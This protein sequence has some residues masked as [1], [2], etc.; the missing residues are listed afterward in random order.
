MKILV[1]VGSFPVLSET[2]IYNQVAG[3]L[4]RGH[5]VH[6][7]A[8]RPGK[9][10]PVQPLV[11]RYQLA[12]RTTF[13]LPADLESFDVI[14]C[15]YGVHASQFFTIPVHLATCFRGY[16]LSKRV[17]EEPDR[18]RRLFERG[19]LFL[20]VC[21]YF[22]DRLVALGCDPDRIV[23]LHSAID[24]RHFAFRPRQPE[25]D[26]TIRIVGTGRLIEKKGFADGIQAVIELRR[27]YP[28]LQYT[29]I[30]D[31][32]MM[33]PLQAQVR[34]AGVADAVQLVGAQ[35]HDVVAKILDQAHLFL[36]PSVTAADGNE[37]G[38]PN[39]LKEA[40]AMGL[41]VVS[42]TH[43]GIP[44]L[45]DDGVNG[46]L[47][48]PRQPAALIACLQRLIESPGDWPRL[49][50]AGRAR[51]EADFEM[52]RTNAQLEQLLMALCKKPRRCP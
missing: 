38:I 16:D 44:E 23:V 39:A 3:L 34:Q 46:Y 21:R 14:L 49:G 31:G 12:R 48:P 26:G 37:E 41:P 42:T 24:C 29:I 35:A 32:P 22:A 27:Q 45:V 51:V 18:Y 36:L 17:Q 7:S 5:D 28:K 47:A 30:G 33:G 19:D 52:D 20:P 10:G 11:E 13:H 40:M 25:P 43:A 8:S 6:I 15:Q 2:P 1:V 4:D 9:P 50:R